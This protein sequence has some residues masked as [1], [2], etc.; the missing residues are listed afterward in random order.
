MDH[1]G[2]D[3]HKK[4][5]QVCILTAEGEVLETRIATRR[6]RF[7]E[8]LKGRVGKVLIESSTESEWVARCLEE[9]GQEVIV[10]DPNFAPMYGMRSRRVKTDLRDARALAE[11]CRSGVYRSAYRRSERQ[12]RV[13]SELVVREALVRSRTSFIAVARAL[14]RKEGL[15]VPGGKAETF[16]ERVARM[17]LPGRLRSELAPLLA[18][19]VTV[20]QQVAWC[21]GALART[22]RS[23]PVV[24]LLQTAPGV[25]PV[26]AAAFR[27]TVDDA[28]RFRGAHQLEAYLGLVPGES[29]SG[30]KLRRGRITRTGDA[31]MRWLLVQ[32][33]QCIRLSKSSCAAGLQ[34]WTKRIETR[35]GRAVATVALA[36][37]LAGILFAMMRD[38]KPF[39][40]GRQLGVVTR[41]AA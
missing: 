18:T 29:S 30:E 22:T 41:A 1:V 12:R 20:N 16:P 19:M 25:G 31:R 40:A 37:K 15:R 5:S 24:A 17:E 9:L 14:L 23:D 34:L 27:A 8:V 36:R 21:D 38:G 32:A 26:T 10:A 39:D 3:V 7:A 6:E 35:R 28:G 4:E 13:T 2:I 11:A 33:A